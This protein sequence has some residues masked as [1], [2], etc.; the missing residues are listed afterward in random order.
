MDNKKKINIDSQTQAQETFY[1][2]SEQK[3]TEATEELFTKDEFLTFID[4]VSLT[5]SLKEES[6]KRKKKTSR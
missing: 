3:A 2:S 6:T 5:D 1:I 4:K